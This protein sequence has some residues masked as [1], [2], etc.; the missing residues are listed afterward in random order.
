M[1]DDE[2]IH[3]D[4]SIL[5][6]LSIPILEGVNGVGVSVFVGDVSLSYGDQ[7]GRHED[8]EKSIRKADVEHVSVDV[9]SVYCGIVNE[10]YLLLTYDKA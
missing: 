7:V 8:C 2:G 3:R 9:G 6:V 5:L 1:E 4:H 10:P